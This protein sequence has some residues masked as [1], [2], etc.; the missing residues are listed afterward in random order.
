M[1]GKDA[2]LN[3]CNQFSNVSVEHIEHAI[4]NA[5]L[6]EQG[7]YRELNGCPSSYGRDDFP[8]LCFEEDVEGNDAKMDQCERCWIKA[9]EVGGENN[10]KNHHQ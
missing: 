2:V 6:I 5:K 4:E 8:G 3:Y 10:E 7:R 1:S 9:L